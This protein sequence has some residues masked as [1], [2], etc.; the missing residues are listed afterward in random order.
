MLL[1]Q[2]NGITIKGNHNVWYTTQQMTS[3]KSDISRALSHF[4]SPSNIFSR[5]ESWLGE[6]MEKV[7]VTFAD[8]QCSMTLVSI[9]LF[10]FDSHE[11]TTKCV[12]V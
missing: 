1:K 12:D 5:K 7:P 11:T 10:S 3:W 4:P 9:L 6:H 2:A 8:I